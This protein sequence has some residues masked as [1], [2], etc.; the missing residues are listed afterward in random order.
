VPLRDYAI[1]SENMNLKY[2]CTDHYYPCCGKSICAG[3]IY[4]FNESG[5]DDK[6]P[7]CN[8]NQADKSDEKNMQELMKRIEANDAEAMY[9]LGSHYHH[10]QRGLQQN[11]ERAMELWTQAAKLGSSDVHYE[12]GIHFHDGGRDMKKAKFH[13]E[14]AA[15]AGHENARYNLGC[16]DFSSGNISRGLEHFR[17]AASAGSH[18]AMHSFL[19][20]FNQGMVSRDAID[21]TLIAYN[22]CCAEMRSEARDAYIRLLIDRFDEN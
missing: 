8:A 15:M 20:S 7:F 16:I 3:C 13:Y 6:C 14:A 9:V 12:L 4:S 19:V 22:N 5:N 11:E 1:T 18:L 17:I 2:E 21:S 10:G